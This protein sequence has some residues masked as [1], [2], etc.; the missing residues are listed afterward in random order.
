MKGGEF[1]IA[2]DRDCPRNTVSVLRGE[3][4]I[5][6][7][8]STAVNKHRWWMLGEGRGCQ[9]VYCAACCIATERNNVSASL[10]RLSVAAR[11]H[12]GRSCRPPKE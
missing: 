1:V 6:V 7:D 4:G 10:L 12:R 3:K 5:P 2:R 8:R 11:I 9:A